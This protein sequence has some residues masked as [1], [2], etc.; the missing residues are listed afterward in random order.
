MAV[1]GAIIP[2]SERL[3][4][5]PVLSREA[6]L[7]LRWFNY[8]QSH[9][10]NV[11]LTCRYFGISRRTFYYWKPHYEAKGAA[12]LENR[13]KRPKKI[14]K[15]KWDCDLLLKV[16]EL[17]ELYP[18]WG[19]EK[20]ARLEGLKGK[21]S[22]STV[23]R[24]L[25]HLKETGRLKEPMVRAISAKKRHKRR[26]ARRKPEDYEVKE[27]G[28]LVEVDTLDVRP[29]PGVVL[30]QFSG[31]DVVSRWDVVETHRRATATSASL[32]LDTLEARMPFRIKAI[33]VDGGSE[34]YAQFERECEKRQIRLFELPPRS[35][36]LNGHV[37]RAQRTHTEEFY[38]VWADRL[39]WTVE[40]LNEQLRKWERIYNEVR[41]HQAL[42]YLTPA[43]WLRQHEAERRKEN[44]PHGGYPH[45]PPSVWPS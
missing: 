23:G 28:D 12:G 20:L 40:G 16:L 44:E 17:R 13:P 15:P 43:E 27:P 18:R 9:N 31:R 1:Y 37:E 24:M 36:K 6:K 25:K 5:I 35:P 39:D 41:P 42:G 19:K 30:K 33:Q 2:G 45:G 8:W 7:R 21:V 32:Y 3:A 11:S 34:F 26:Y 4:R 22:V 10:H 29:L 14:A 38:E